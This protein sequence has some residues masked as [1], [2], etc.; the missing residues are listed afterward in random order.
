MCGGII[1]QPQI[2][3]LTTTTAPTGTRTLIRGK[4]VP[5]SANQ[6]LGLALGDQVVVTATAIITV[7]NLAYFKSDLRKETAV[8][9][10]SVM[11][12]TNR[13]KGTS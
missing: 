4:E 1:G 7:S 10:F 3:P 6:V 13:W 5:E 9:L 2:T 12:V 11:T 8:Q